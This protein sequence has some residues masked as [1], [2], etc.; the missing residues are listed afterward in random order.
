MVGPVSVGRAAMP[1]CA[2]TA[3]SSAIVTA[4]GAVISMPIGCASYVQVDVQASICTDR[5]SD[6]RPALA[7]QVQ[8]R[9]EQSAF[10]NGDR[11]VALL[12]RST[13]YAVTI[14]IRCPIEPGMPRRRP[15]PRLC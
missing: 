3:F 13:P 14:T 10:A 1:C 11:E 2:R 5:P 6:T 15:D 8:I 9:G 7:R 12:H 4:A